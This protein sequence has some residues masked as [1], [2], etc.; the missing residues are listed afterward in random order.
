M[1]NN[2]IELNQAVRMMTAGAPPPEAV[3]GKMKSCGILVAESPAEMGKTL[4]DK[5]A[6]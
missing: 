3:L 4:Q 6:R 2:E 5:L 1:I